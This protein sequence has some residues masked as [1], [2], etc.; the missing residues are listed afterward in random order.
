MRWLTRL[1]RLFDVGKQLVWADIATN[2]S[3]GSPGG[4]VAGR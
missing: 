1:V 2:S 3:S 4:L